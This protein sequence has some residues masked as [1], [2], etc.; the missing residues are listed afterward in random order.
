MQ[1]V[2]PTRKILHTNAEHSSAAVQVLSAKIGLAP[3]IEVAFYH[4][5]AKVLLVTDAVIFIP[6]DPPEVIILTEACNLAMLCC[7]TLRFAMPCFPMLCFAMLCCA[8]L[9]CA[10]LCHAMLCHTMLCYAMLHKSHWLL[11]MHAQHRNRTEQC[12]LLC[13]SSTGINCSAL[14]RTTS[15]CAYCTQKTKRNQ[16][17]TEMSKKS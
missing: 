12:G 8:M 13:R 11:V 17:K 3:Y 4:K 5:A 15:L 14:G 9:R 16:S 10:V 2:V 7:A 6:E 1:R